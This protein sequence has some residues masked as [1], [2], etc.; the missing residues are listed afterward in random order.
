MDWRNVAPPLHKR[1]HDRLMTDRTQK[2]ST[3]WAPRYLDECHTLSRV[4]WAKLSYWLNI[5]CSGNF[6]TRVGCSKRTGQHSTEGSRILWK[7]GCSFGRH[8]VALSPAERVRGA[9]QIVRVTETVVKIVGKS[10]KESIIIWTG[11]V[12]WWLNQTILDQSARSR[13][14]SSAYIFNVYFHIFR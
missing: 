5:C 8:H 13:P 14:S 9:S 12:D 2:H 11:T 7:R 10:P 1:H 4:F 6:Y 3:G